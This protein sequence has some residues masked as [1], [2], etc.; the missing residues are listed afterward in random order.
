MMN[1]FLVV[2]SDKGYFLQLS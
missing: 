1:D 2:I